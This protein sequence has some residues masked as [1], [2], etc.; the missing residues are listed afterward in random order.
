MLV[1]EFKSREFFFVVLQN[2][3]TKNDIFFLQKSE[4]AEHV[5]LSK[6]LPLSLVSITRLRPYKI[7]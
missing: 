7:E 2:K 3:M 1:Q 4:I 6:Y 5:I